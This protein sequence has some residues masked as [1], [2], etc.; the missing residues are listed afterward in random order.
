MRSTTLHR[1]LIPLLFCSTALLT[2]A[3]SR[4]APSSDASSESP[5]TILE[6]LMTAPHLQA[7]WFAPGFAMNGT[8]ATAAQLEQGRQMTAA[9]LG[10]YH[11]LEAQPAGTF[12]LLYQR[13]V[14]QT[15]ISLDRLGRI[16]AL[17][18]GSP[19]LNAERYD[20]GGYH[21]FLHCMGTGSPTVL[22]EAGLGETSDV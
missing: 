2:P 11:G 13:A 17:A 9:A 3:G 21:L 6:R 4:A 1:L 7:A 20:V 12:L 16:A 19:K 18:F 22:L 14:V 15:Q 5:R 10:P 8:P